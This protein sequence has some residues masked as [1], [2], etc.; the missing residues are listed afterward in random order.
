MN[1]LQK[2]GG[3]VLYALLFI[4]AIYWYTS[5]PAQEQTYPRND[6]ASTVIDK[7]V[8]AV[9]DKPAVLVKNVPIGSE[10]NVLPTRST[11]KETPRAR[12]RIPHKSMAQTVQD[13]VLTRKAHGYWSAQGDV[14]LDERNLTEKFKDGDRGLAKIE[15]SYWLD[16]IPYRIDPSLDERKTVIEAAIAEVNEKT[17]AKFIPHNGESDYVTFTLPPQ[18]MQQCYSHLGFMG[19]EQLIMLNMRCSKGSIIHELL[20]TLGIVHEQSRSDRDSHITVLWDNIHPYFHNQFNK[21]P[22]TV[23]NPA[24]LPFD[25]DS[26]MLYGSDYFTLKGENPGMTKVIDGSSFI[27]NRIG[28]SPTDIQEVN[29]IY[30]QF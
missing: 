8:V 21:L 25:F 15:P 10:L 28:L 11:V 27:P 17:Q 2:Q 20:H 16:P 13:I 29:S 9:T 22:A 19:G 24:D 1:V 18:E 12:P 7:S 14:I 23:S 30:A 6:T 5:P 26:I 3:S 4:G